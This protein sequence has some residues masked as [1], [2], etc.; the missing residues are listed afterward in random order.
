MK[1]R[2]LKLDS[3]LALTSSLRIEL[4]ILIPLKNTRCCTSFLTHEKFTVIRSW[5]RE[6]MTAVL[7]FLIDRGREGAVLIQPNFSNI[8]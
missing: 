8:C 6:A 3:V 4:P 5:Q 2:A 7:F 1:F